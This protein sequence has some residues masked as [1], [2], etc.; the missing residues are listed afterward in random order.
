MLTSETSHP[1]ISQDR[2]VITN[3]KP[4]NH[5]QSPGVL[6]KRGVSCI[7]KKNDKELFAQQRHSGEQIT[8]THCTACLPLF[9]LQSP[10]KPPNQHYIVAVLSAGSAQNFLKNIWFYSTQLTKLI[11]LFCCFKNNFICL[12]AWDLSWG[13]SGGSSGRRICLPVQ[14]RQQMRLRSLGQED[15]LE[16]GLGN[17]S[18]DP[19]KWQPTPGFLPG[20]FHEQR[21]LAVYNPWG[22]KQSRHVWA[23]NTHAHYPPR[24]NTL[25]TLYK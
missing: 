1:I 7:K 8:C 17:G 24:F 13:F 9:H 5:G 11:H 2:P 16:W 19:R 14:E 23:T 15:P 25:G 21:S 10:Y 3:A 4:H 6:K 20:E 18:K 12:T 22:H